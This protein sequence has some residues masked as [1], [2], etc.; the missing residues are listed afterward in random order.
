M[1]NDKLRDIL[2]QMK[3]NEIG[4]VNRLQTELQSSEHEIETQRQ[5][6]RSLYDE[7]IDLKQKVNLLQV[8]FM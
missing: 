3:T 1:E 8:I 4:P 2:L 7:T 5:T 6:N